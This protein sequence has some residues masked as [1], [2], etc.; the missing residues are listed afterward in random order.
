M[1]S[2]FLVKIAALL[3]CIWIVVFSISKIAEGKIATPERALALVQ[4]EP[5]TPDLDANERAKRINRLAKVVNGL[6]FQQRQQFRK[7]D[8]KEMRT[9]FEAMTAEEQ[10]GFVEQTM[11][12]HFTAVMHAFNEMDPEERKKTIAQ[13]RKEM[14]RNEDGRVELEKMESQDREIFEKVVEQGVRSY[15]QEASVESKME[16][17][18]LLEEMQARI[19]GMH[20]H[21]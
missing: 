12:Q 18:P 16:L 17:A 4:E 6:D 13:I 11:E 21:R 5:L 2:A 15:Y 3:I 8:G 14:S 7:E 1:P 10:A 19:Q 20:R 9:F